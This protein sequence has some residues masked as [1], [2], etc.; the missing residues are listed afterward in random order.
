MKIKLLIVLVVIFG[1]L[2]VMLA[3]SN[4]NTQPT[5]K[6]TPVATSSNSPPPAPVSRL[7]PDGVDPS[8]AVDT[9]GKA[10]PAQ[11]ATQPDKPIILSKDI[12]DP[13]YGEMKPEAA[14]DHTKHSTDVMYSLDGKTVTACVDCHHTD[15]P[16]SSLPYLKKFERKDVLTAKQLEDSKEPVKSCRN[17]HY[18]AASEETDEYPP[19]GVTYPKETGKPPLGKLTNDV[20]YHTKCISCHNAAKQRDAQL[21]APQACLDCHIKK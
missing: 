3:C 18:Q 12:D 5:T 17:C 6:T 9:S 8:H 7:R 13:K 4:S 11:S 14:F 20:A 21:K 15:Q 16:S 2:A 19:K 1:Y 10:I